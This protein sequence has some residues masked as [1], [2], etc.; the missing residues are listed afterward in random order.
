[1]AAAI[2]GAALQQVAASRALLLRNPLAQAI[3]VRNLQGLSVQ[4]Q[5]A[6]IGAQQQLSFL[7]PAIAAQLQGQSLLLSA[8]QLPQATQQVPQAYD[9]AALL[10][11]QARLQF[12]TSQGANPAFM[13][14]A[15]ARNAA[16]AGT[17][18]IGEQYLGSALTAAIPGYPAVAANTYR[19]LT[20]FAPY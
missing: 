2:Q 19:A 12:V 18:A 3:A 15:A 4:G 8:A 9:P 1:L 17:P 20:R 7:N 14:A 6:A 11:E 16:T 10:T 5:L 13:A